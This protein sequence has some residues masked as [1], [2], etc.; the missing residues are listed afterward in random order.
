[1]QPE[2]VCVGAVNLD[3]LF[4]AQDL[5]PFQA[6]WPDLRPGAELALDEGDEALLQAL[7]EQYAHWLGYASGGQAANTAYALARLGVA[8]ALVGR[9]GEDEAGE[10]LLAGLAGVDVSRVT[11]EGRSGRA[12]ILVD[13]QGERTIFVAPHTNDELCDADVPLEDLA[14]A[15]WVHFTSFVGEGPLQ[16]QTAVAARLKELA[17]ASRGGQGRERGAGYGPRLSLDPGELYARRGR[18]ALA[19]LLAATETLF[20]TETEWQ[21]LGGDPWERPAWAP[22]VVLVKRGAA[23]ARLLTAAGLHDFPAPRVGA[24]D[25]V[26]AG[27]VFAAGYLAGRLKGLSLPQAVRLAV[28]AAAAS[29]SGRGREAYPDAAF[30]ERQLQLLL[31]T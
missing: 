4:Q 30:L 17:E 10:F 3:L 5:R 12:Y 21:L 1:M 14:Q 23:G 27:D 20:V 16:V 2:V 18:Q 24:V 15:P 28:V 26:G 19:G 31:D 29:V 8:A 7:L 13:R 22:P 6:V 11:W 25:T 9:V